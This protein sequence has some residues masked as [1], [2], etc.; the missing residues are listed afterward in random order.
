M[1]SKKYNKY[2]RAILFNLTLIK[3]VFI[4]IV[5]FNMFLP[6]YYPA[7]LGI[8]SVFQWIVVAVHLY[9]MLNGVGVFIKQNI[10]IVQIVIVRILETLWYVFMPWASFNWAP[11]AIVLFLDVVFIFILLMDK[12]TYKY[13][14]VSRRS[15]NV[16]GKS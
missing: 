16:S 10:P 11:Y 8:T 12:A 7:R 15:S 3:C 14:K 4:V 1:S 5:L 9:G 13:E 2:E 6:L